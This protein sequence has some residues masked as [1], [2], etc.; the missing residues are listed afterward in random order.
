MDAIAILLAFV[1]DKLVELVVGLTVQ[2]L[3]DVPS[4]YRLFYRFWYGLGSFK[5]FLIST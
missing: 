3:S 4:K 1:G 2:S 5:L